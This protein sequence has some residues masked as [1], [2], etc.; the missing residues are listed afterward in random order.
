MKLT[1][2]IDVPN[3]S[4][5]IPRDLLYA[6]KERLSGTPGVY[7]I[8]GKRDDEILYIGQSSSLFSRLCDHAHGRGSSEAFHLDI[9]YFEVYVVEDG[10]HR[11]LFETY[12]IHNDKPSYNRDKVFVK[13]FSSDREYYA[14][15][16]IQE[17][18][19][20]KREL[21]DDI[22]R[23][24]SGLGGS[25]YYGEDDIDYEELSAWGD[26]LLHEQ[27]IREIDKEIRELRK[28]R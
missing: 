23:H 6:N 8:R 3:E 24:R 20:E 21:K 2:E 17:L 25:L 12:A 11:E 1:V 7:Y 13:G 9:K 16:S 19:E 15:V 27:R 28:I 14:N 5:E 18:L 22:Y 26:V 4:Y 10:Y